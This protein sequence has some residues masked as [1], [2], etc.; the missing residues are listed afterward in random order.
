M[1]ICVPVRTH[2]MVSH[3]AISI[4]YEKVEGRKVHGVNKKLQRQKIIV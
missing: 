4:F 3:I 1:Y 2:G